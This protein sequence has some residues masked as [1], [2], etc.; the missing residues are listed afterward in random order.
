[1]I[2]GSGSLLGWGIGRNG[3]EPDGAHSDRQ[4]TP[5]DPVC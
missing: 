2:R 1:V 4:L 3:T 5:P